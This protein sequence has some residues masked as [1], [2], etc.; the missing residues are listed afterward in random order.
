MSG[1]GWWKVVKMDDFPKKINLFKLCFEGDKR[2]F[3]YSEIPDTEDESDFVRRG[4]DY[5]SL[6]KINGCEETEFNPYKI[7]KLIENAFKKKLSSN[8]YSFNRKYVVYKENNKIPHK[9]E[10]EGIFSIFKGFEYR[11]VPIMNDMFLCIDYKLI[12]KFNASIQDL[13]DLNASKRSLIGNSV[14]FKSTDREERNGLLIGVEDHGVCIVDFYEGGEKSVSADKLYLLCRPEVIQH[15]LKEM[16]RSENV[17]SLQRQHSLLNP[18]RR[19]VEIKKVAKSLNDEIF[20]ILIE[21]LDIKLDT[22]PLPIEEVRYSTFYDGF[23]LKCDTLSEEPELQFDRGSSSDIQPRPT[24][25]PPYSKVEDLSLI[26]YY[27]EAKEREIEVLCGDLERYFRNYFYLDNIE[28]SK[29]SIDSDPFDENYVERIQNSLKFNNRSDI[30]I[31]YVPEVMKYYQNSPY[32]KLKAYFASQGIP[33][34]MVTDRSFIPSKYPLNYT[35]LNLCT[36][37]I[38]KC[39]GVPWVLRTKLKETDIVIGMSLSARLSNIGENIQMNRYIG[40][41]NIFNE[42]GKWMY[43]CG[44][45]QKYEKNQQIEQIASIIS[46][47]KGYYSNNSYLIPKN[48]MIHNSKRFKRD[49]RDKIY[50]LLKENFG[51]DTK[52]A[53]VTI[54]ESHNYRAFDLNSGDGSFQRGYFI[55]LNERGILLSTTGKSNF[56][57]A[58][59]QGTPKLLHITVDQYPK[60]FLNLENVAYQVLA[61]TKLNWASATS[62]AQREPV[63]IKYANKLAKV[64]ANM[65]SSQWNR[66]NDRLFNRPWFI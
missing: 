10:N 33:T 54:D 18:R 19:L 25:Y 31:I 6:K 63:T 35:I 27:P 41:A 46:E 60:K 39:G 1:L 26:F 55:Y 11:F 21:G 62:P 65:G 13:L 45:A 52:V 16:R 34:Q 59:R 44:T 56:K 23:T 8:S 7:Q 40:F 32:Y 2:I 36:G 42:Y 29:E 51:E 47:I 43:F 28:I 61:L 24:Q 49:D 64:V 38:A 57:G 22:E 4:N 15:I 30:G 9:Q 66:I 20:P 12:I 50:E 14:K 5:F 53:F 37:I 58:F 48:I 3:K 17:I